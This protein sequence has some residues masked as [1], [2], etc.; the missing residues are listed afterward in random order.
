MTDP[1]SVELRGPI[2]LWVC[3]VL[4]AVSMARGTTRLEVVRE[5]LEPWAKERIHESTLVLRV[6]RR[7]GH[8]AEKDGEGTE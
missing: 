1:E 6:S 8:A 7:N 2:P 3:E 4:D 5:V